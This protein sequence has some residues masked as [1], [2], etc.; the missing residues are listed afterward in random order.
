MLQN[1]VK[2]ERGM[3]VNDQRKQYAGV[4]RLLEKIVVAIAISEGIIAFPP[5]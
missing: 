5:I 4:P 3:L 2:G 1:F